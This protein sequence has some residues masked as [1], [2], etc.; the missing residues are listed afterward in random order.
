MKLLKD[1]GS[2]HGCAVQG[3]GRVSLTGRVLGRRSAS[4]RGLQTG[5]HDLC[6]GEL[7]VLLVLVLVRDEDELP[8]EVES[9]LALV[10]GGVLDANLE[11]AFRSIDD[12][13]VGV[14]LAAGL[15]GLHEVEQAL[16]HLVD[17]LAVLLVL[18]HELDQE[19]QLILVDLDGLHLV[20]EDVGALLLPL[21]H[22]RRRR[23]PVLHLLRC[24]EQLV[25]VEENHLDD[26]HRR[27]VLLPFLGSSIIL[28]LLA[29]FLGSICGW[30]FVFGLGLR[31]FEGLDSARDRGVDLGVEF[32]ISE[33]VEQLQEDDEDLL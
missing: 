30:I 12:A 7:D 16:V 1:R 24:S 10:D 31:L 17:D 2:E 3:C 27:R 25:Q 28:R 5:W 14:G 21:G 29:T 15:A 8:Q 4:S 19:L 22:A 18:H 23:V 13:D 6:Q 26:G 20:G 9:H 33:S 32:L 11:Q